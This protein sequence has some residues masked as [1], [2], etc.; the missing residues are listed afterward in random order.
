M[1]IVAS[2][3]VNAFEQRWID[4]W[5]RRNWLKSDKKPVENQDLWRLLLLTIRK[6]GHIMTFHKVKGH[7]DHPE[8]IRC[9]ALAR[10]AIQDYIKRYSDMGDADTITISHSNE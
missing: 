2:T 10:Q 6:K 5:V 4:G 7:A 8:N 3:L 9:D 1:Q